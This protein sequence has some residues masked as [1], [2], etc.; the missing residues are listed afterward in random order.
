MLCLSYRDD[1]VAHVHPFNSVLALM[2]SAHTVRVHLEQLSH[3]AVARLSKKTAYDPEALHKITGGKPFF[4]AELLAN[5]D[6]N[7]HTIPASIRE[8]VSSR[9]QHLGHAERELL[10]VLSLVPY[11][12]PVALINELFGENGESFTLACVARKLLQCDQ[13]SVFRFRHELVRRAILENQP[14]HQQKTHTS[15]F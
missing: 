8:A 1:E 11:S 9:V 12:I 13:Y 15:E 14:A 10:Q 6:Y 7:H 4:I 3:D 5:S 2:P